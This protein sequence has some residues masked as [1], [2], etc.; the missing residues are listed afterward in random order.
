MFSSR[1][2][3]DLRA[4]RLTAARQR[5]GRVPF[6][7]T[8]TNPTACDLPYP[9]SLLEP[10][11][12]PAALRYHPD[13]LGDRGA[14]E[15]VAATYTGLGVD[16][17]PDRVVLSASTSEAYSCLFRLLAD[18]GD[19]FLVPTPSYPLFEHLLRLDALHGAPYRLDPDARWRV[20]LGSLGDAPATTRG[21][22]LVHPN[23]PTGSHVHPDDAVRLASLC[24]EQGWALVADEVFLPFPLRPHPGWD[25]TFAGRADCLTFTLGGLSKSVGL[26]QMKLAWTVVGGPEPEVVEALARLEHI[27]DAYLSVA[28]PTALAARRWLEMGGTVRAAINH[29]CR[30]NL[31]ALLA[32]AERLPAV[33]VDPPQGGWSAVLRVP[34]VVDEETLVLGLLERD[35]VAVFP[36]FF[37][38]FP[39]E[40]WL[41]VSLLPPEELFAEGI[42][43][44]LA[45]VERSL[46]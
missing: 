41:V 3:Q 29:R 43:R 27:A 21:L 8:V 28:T 19:S 31:D 46:G 33:R 15:A 18:P 42:R 23:N 45:T 26:P 30:S 12:D 2:P 11:A 38:D 35:G 4:N 34:T 37:F 7:L 24:A 32:L 36:G 40:G 17:D 9:E 22:I 10:L 39:T 44:L 14:R 5:L 6:D 1:V 16:V 25:H 20:D 13:P